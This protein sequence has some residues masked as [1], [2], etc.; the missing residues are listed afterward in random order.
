L[1]ES[2]LRDF[3]AKKII[4]LEYEQ[5][6]KELI[7]SLIKEKGI[8]VHG[9]ESRVKDRDSLS[10]KIRR[11][12]DKYNALEDI[13]DTLGLRIIT[14][15]EDDVDRIA[16][17]LKEQFN[18]DDNN[19][20]DKRKKNNPDTFGYA[21]L[22]YVL[23]L[24]EPRNSLP[25]YQRFK[26]IQFELQIRSIL[27]HAW[28]EIEHDIGYKNPVSIPKEIRRNSSRISSLLELADIEFIRIKEE[29]KNYANEV[30]ENIQFKQLDIPIDKI[31]LKEFIKNSKVIKELDEFL[32][33]EL[34][35]SILVF[36]EYLIENNIERLDFFNIQ[37]IELLE[38]ILLDNKDHIKKFAKEFLKKEYPEDEYLDTVSMGIS[39]FYMGYILIGKTQELDEALR[40]LKRFK[41]GDN[42]KVDARRIIDIYKD[43]TK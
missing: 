1:S 39:I 3:D 27:Q 30:K 23:K 13:T 16:N 25:E 15:F 24:K 42:S 4:Y 29:I 43:I 20:V 31:T 36:S 6:I 12:E 2:I 11:K 33:K 21:S 40:Y 26:E 19:S 8:T 14:Y 32:L 5:K 41:I 37:T 35:G 22:H 17:I 28:A 9:I 34:K 10:K 38:K 7:N 18:L